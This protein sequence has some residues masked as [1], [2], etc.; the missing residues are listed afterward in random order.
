MVA[1]FILMA[2][3]SMG[4][5][6]VG[7]VTVHGVAF[8]SLRGIAL[9]GAF[10]VVVGAGRST[11]TDTR[12][13]FRFDSIAPGPYTFA[14]QHEALDS[15]GVSSI[16]T[17]V[18][19]SDG[20]DTV[21]VAIQSF[22]SVWR[23][24][25]VG[26]APRDSGI[27]FG[28]VR[29]GAGTP[30]SG[31]L[32]AASW[33]DVSLDERKSMRQQRW[34]LDVRTDPTGAYRLCGVPSGI[35]LRIHARGD[36]AA[37]G[38]I[39][40]MPRDLAIRR[41]DLV[42]GDANGDARGAISGVVT[43]EDGGPVSGARVATDGIGEVRTDAAGRFLLHGVP[44]GTRQVDVAAIGMVPVAIAID[45]TARD[46]TAAN[47]QVRKVTLLD[48]VKVK[49]T[50]VRQRMV[51]DIEERRSKGFGHF[52]DSSTIGAHGKIASVF[53]EMPGVR[54]APSGVVRFGLG[55]SGCTPNV[56]ID[57]FRAD[58]T[59]TRWLRPDEVAVVEVYTR[60]LSMPPEF[61]VRRNRGPQCGSIVIW[62]KRITP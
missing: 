11:T 17:R 54:V 14:L 22:A 39:D 53:E 52:A 28:T 7:R 23:A 35:G 51:A 41:R 13:R 58:T 16:S 60:T 45:V 21:K 31:A 5:Q 25:C 15:I 19:V 2:S 61:F 50:S 20:R 24:S 36:S 18:V 10:V 6:N 47:V 62:T 26:N 59:D 1:A 3:A 43:A 29:G 42:L 46:T 40:L 33:V 32:V 56:F 48:P 57:G 9:N 27:V 4:A 8:D 12:G 34:T 30:I 55:P 37:T 44:T 49:A 38:L